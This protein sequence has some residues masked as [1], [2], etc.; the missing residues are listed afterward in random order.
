MPPERSL[1]GRVTPDLAW[2]AAR[3]GPRPLPVR[4][5]RRAPQPIQTNPASQGRW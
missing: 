2:N 4:G 3:R 1:L 5:E